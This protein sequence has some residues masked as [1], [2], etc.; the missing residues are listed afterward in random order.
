MPEGQSIHTFLRSPGEILDVRSPS[1]F[2]YGHIPLSISFPL[3]S[4]EE[5]AV[6]GTLYK[7]EGRT[8]AVDHGLELVLPKIDSLVE[9]AKKILPGNRGRVICW[10]GGMRS[11]FIARLLESC[12]FS[13]VTLNGGYKSF[14][15]YVLNYLLKLSE[16]NL[17]LKVIGGL[18]G[19]GKTSHLNCLKMDGHQVLDLEKLANH[20]GSAFGHIGFGMQPSQ[21]HFENSLV[22][23]LEQFDL[24]QPI[25]IEDE[26][27]LI[28]RC[29]LPPTLYHLIRSA[30]LYYLDTPMEMRL[31]NLM[32][33]YGRASLQ[34]MIGAVQR[35]A[36]RLGSQMAIE[37]IQLLEQDRKREAFN[38]LLIYYDRT[39]QHNLQQRNSC[40]RSQL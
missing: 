29:C 3:F 40:Q 17:K 30:P 15:R 12:G 10:R 22:A 31:N 37:V 24:T 25:W 13:M 20:R 4:D 28:G 5:R 16:L 6:V 18:T 39:Y 33:E 36:K 23:V 14:R 27:R 2:A 21:E 9:R 19:S 7:K 8:E 38:Q 11:G 1:E 35:I 26:S 32:E 34:D